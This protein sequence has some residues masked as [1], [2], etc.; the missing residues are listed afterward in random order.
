MVQGKVGHHSLGQQSKELSELDDEIVQLEKRIA[1]L[2]ESAT[3]PADNN[4]NNNSNKKRSTT[5]DRQQRSGNTNNNLDEIFD[6]VNKKNDLL[7]RQMQLNILE[8]EKALE[9]ANEELSKELRSLMSID[10]SIKSR[11]ELDRQQYLYDQ[12][13]ALVNKRNELVHH[14]DDQERG[15]EDDNALKATLKTVISSSNNGRYNADQNC[16][17]Q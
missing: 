15:I 13:L 4:L 1:A 10:D 12:S 7:R 6:L 17:I 11:A 5:S 3:S 9:K 16:C 2:N 8:Q 14:M